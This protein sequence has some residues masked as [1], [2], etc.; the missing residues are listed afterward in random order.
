MRDRIYGRNMPK[1]D[2]AR[3]GAILAGLAF[4]AC[5]LFAACTIILGEDVQGT[6]AGNGGVADPMLDILEQELN[7]SYDAALA[8]SAA[9]AARALAGGANSI[10]H[11]LPAAS[12]AKVKERVRERI[13]LAGLEKS[14]DI[15]KVNPLIAT[16]TAEALQDESLVGALDDADLANAGA[17]AVR[18]ASKAINAPSVTANAEGLGTAAERT[19][20]LAAL[21]QAAA[22]GAA[23]MGLDADGQVDALQKLVMVMLA[24]GN[25]DQ[26]ASDAAAQ[27]VLTERSSAIIRAAAARLDSP[28]YTGAD[29]SAALNALANAAVL[30]LGGTSAAASGA[31]LQAVSRDGVLTGLFV[32]FYRFSADPGIGSADLRAAID[33]NEAMT[34]LGSGAFRDLVAAQVQAERATIVPA[35]DTAARRIAVISSPTIPEQT[36]DA[37]AASV[38]SGAT[39]TWTSGSSIHV[40]NTITVNGTLVIQPGV[41]VFMDAGRG[42]TVSATGRIQAQGTLEAPIVFAR[43]NSTSAWG[44]ISVA[45]GGNTFSHCDFQGGTNALTITGRAEVSDCLF[46]GNS[47]NGLNCADATPD[48]SVVTV[49]RDCYFYG[50]ASYPAIIN[51]YVDFDSSNHFYDPQGALLAPD[52]AASFNAIQFV[53]D[54]SSAVTLSVAE[55]PYCR[56]SLLNINAPSGRLTIGP[57]VIMKFG[58]GIGIRAFQ[59]SQVRAEG[60]AAARVIFTSFTDSTV[61]GRTNGSDLPANRGDWDRIDVMCAGAVFTFCEFRFATQAIVFND[62]ADQQGN[63]AINACRFHHN[64]Q[65]GVNAALAKAGTTV[66]S[67]CFWANTSYPA[68]VNQNVAMGDSNHFF[69][70]SSASAPDL[71]VANAAVRFYG[72]VDVPVSLNVS[73]VP[74]VRLELLNVYSSL[75]IGPGV[76]MKFQTSTGIRAFEGAQVNA[77]GTSLRPIIFTAYSDSSVGGRTNG[78]DLPAV[79]GAWTE[80]DIMCAGAVFTHCEFRYAQCGLIF[81]DWSNAVGSA[82]VSACRFHH[83]SIHGINANIAKAGTSVTSSYFWSNGS[84]PVVVNQYTVLDTSNHFF[85]PSSA[86][87]PDLSANFNAIQ[88]YGTVDVP[89]AWTVS[90]VPYFIGG[91]LNVNA[92]P[93]HL[94]IGPGVIVKMA[95]SAY[96]RVF[97]GGL[98]TALGTSGSRVVF[99]SVSD[100]SRGGNTGGNPA[101]VGAPGDWE[102]IDLMSKSN[103]LEYCD[104]R[105]AVTPLVFNDWSNAEGFA[106]VD[107]CAFQYNSAGGIWATRADPGTTISNCTFS[108]NNATATGPYDID[109]NGNANV[110]L[111]DNVY[112]F[113]RN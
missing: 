19:A 105:Y 38:N 2:T 3:A 110:I 83:N 21:A 35:A 77:V 20:Q 16:A 54:I 102:A 74:Y 85:D 112:E 62:W 113:I 91:P 87:Q 56:T 70:P 93:G 48:L 97:A 68:V 72:N 101:A 69:D 13:R 22:A 75:T 4:M 67:C 15:E 6:S 30:G 86:T 34:A 41:F 45:S 111:T 82:S 79:P 26:A 23:G 106:T 53:D 12:V 99:T 31:A 104:F 1:R 46:H 92:A 59:G 107:H 32:A 49:V 44:G 24:A 108:D 109:R 39:V 37:T 76:I 28:A 42:I 78:S 103:R 47:S 90:E 5:A 73:E 40:I 55:V 66:E 88:F 84:Y 57:G 17:V 94:S 7:A 50:N 98:F 61:G 63:A 64:S 52:P 25:A 10:R 27:A 14:R 18:A 51:P 43:A 33:F 36:Y 29:C 65:Y 9:P 58:T 96:I 100:N 11:G 8:S 80:V 71:S 81:N 95:N 60:T 89:V